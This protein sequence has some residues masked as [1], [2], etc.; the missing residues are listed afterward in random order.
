M[1]NTGGWTRRERLMTIVSG[2][3]LALSL[4][5]VL[6]FGG[7]SF[8]S[9]SKVAS[10]QIRNNTIRSIDIRNNTIGGADI[11]NK[12]LTGKDV[13]DGTLT[14]ADSGVYQRFGFSAEIPKN[15]NG[16]AQATC[17]NG[18]LALG[19]G[20]V[21]R[22]PVPQDGF[23]NEPIVWVDQLNQSTPPSGPF[24]QWSVVIYNKTSGPGKIE[25]MVT[26]MNG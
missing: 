9:T 25:V 12:A 15:Q 1:R 20:Y 17:N 19:G 24:D 11:R 3:S 6:G 22:G 2:A 8:A 23:S 5:A 14:A 18:D 21:W 16:Q 10:G 7:V 26:C 4:T 13:A